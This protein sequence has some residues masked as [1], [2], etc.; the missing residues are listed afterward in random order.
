MIAIS[1]SYYNFY[2]L[3]LNALLNILSNKLEKGF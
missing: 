3:T 1:L 2:Y